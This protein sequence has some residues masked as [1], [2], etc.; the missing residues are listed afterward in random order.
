MGS[1]FRATWPAFTLTLV[2]T[3]IAGWALMACCPQAT[4]ITE[5]F[6]F[7]LKT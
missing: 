1:V 3:I 5:V 7:C 2:M 4:K 6:Q